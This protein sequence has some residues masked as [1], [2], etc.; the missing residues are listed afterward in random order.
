ME[1]SKSEL[2]TI[3]KALVLYRLYFYK[4]YLDESFPVNSFSIIKDFENL[5]SLQKKFYEESKKFNQ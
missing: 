4:I 5:N 2:E 1:F 3:E